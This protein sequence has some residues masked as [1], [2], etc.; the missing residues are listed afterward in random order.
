MIPQLL[1]AQVAAA[2]QS[3]DPPVL[4]DVREASRTSSRTGG[5]SLWRAAATWAGRSCGIIGHLGRVLPLR[6][7]IFKKE[8]PWS[9]SLSPI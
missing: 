2:L 1:P 5:S 7:P 8:E 3:D 6:Y 4:L 9:V